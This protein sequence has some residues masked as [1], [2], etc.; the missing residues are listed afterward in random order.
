MKIRYFKHPSHFWL[1]VRRTQQRNLAQKNFTPKQIFPKFAISTTKKKHIFLTILKKTKIT[2]WLN[3]E[4]HKTL[5]LMIWRETHFSFQI[6]FCVL[7]SDIS[8]LNLIGAPYLGYYQVN[9][10]SRN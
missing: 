3:L 4:N 9:A 7:A 2:N 8:I 5:H 10:Q 6:H 1:H